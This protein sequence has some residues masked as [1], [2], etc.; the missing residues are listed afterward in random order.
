MK[1]THPLSP[2]GTARTAFSVHGETIDDESVILDWLSLVRE[3]LGTLYNFEDEVPFLAWELVRWQSGLTLDER[4]AM[5]LLVL[6]ALVHAREGS[7]RIPLLGEAGR[8]FR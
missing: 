2:L 6:S 1:P 8:A 4:R 7:T 3:R 5:I